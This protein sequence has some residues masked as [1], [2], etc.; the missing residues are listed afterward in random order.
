EEAGT[1]IAAGE[2]IVGAADGEFFFPRAHESLARPFAAAVVVDRIDVIEAR[3]E[4]TPQHG[5]A[6]ASGDVPPALGGP[7]VILLVAD[8]DPDPVAGVVAETEVGHRG[9]GVERPG[10]CK[11]GAG[12]QHPRAAPPR[13]RNRK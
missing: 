10:D 12:N 7:A 5:L 6:A 11:Q 1:V 3:D 13:P 9:R 2:T 4:R 8:R